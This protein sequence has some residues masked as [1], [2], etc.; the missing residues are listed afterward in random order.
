MSVDG[1][2]KQNSESNASSSKLGVLG[3]SAAIVATVTLTLVLL[4]F[5]FSLAIESRLALPH[6][7]LYESS[8]ELI[9]LG[10]IAAL[11]IFGKL[12]KQLTLL[13]TYGQLIAQTWQSFWVPFAVLIMLVPFFVNPK[14]IE[15]TKTNTLSAKQWLLDSGR[16]GVFARGVALLLFGLTLLFSPII[17]YLG[18]VVV[19]IVLSIVPIIGWSAGLYLINEVAFNNNQCAPLPSVKHYRLQKS[20]EAKNNAGI[21]YTQCVRV[22]NDNNE[23]GRGFLLLSTSKAV[24]LY[25]PD[26]LA[27]RVP[28]T[29]A[30]IE[31]TDT[32]SVSSHKKD[33]SKPTLEEHSA[34]AEASKKS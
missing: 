6:A 4:G 24:V 33:S 21:N 16:K 27:S 32:L 14:I 12:S 10:S 30:I 18:L 3:V 17:F 2:N 8:V 19:M 7:S 26:G 20:G 34:N 29:E 31:V 13:S 28:I 5:G 25:H 9:D 22:L 23:I 1:N 15:K 11:A